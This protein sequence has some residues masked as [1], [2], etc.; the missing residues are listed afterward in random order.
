[1]REE[2]QK[3]MTIKKKCAGIKEECNGIVGFE[4]GKYR[5]VKGSQILSGATFKPPLAP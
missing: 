3:S 2:L 4:E 5:S 1:M